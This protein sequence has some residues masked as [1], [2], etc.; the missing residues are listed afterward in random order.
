MNSDP[1]Q[2]LAPL[3]PIL[4]HKISLERWLERK[5]PYETE[6][7]TRDIVEEMSLR[8]YQWLSTKDDLEVTIDFD[9]FQTDFINLLYDKY[10][11]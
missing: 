3:V 5:L 1:E 4:Y 8:V 7:C 11:K 6:Y 2:P 9:S 10:L